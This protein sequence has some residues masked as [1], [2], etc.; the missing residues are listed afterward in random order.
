MAYKKLN[1]HICI[2]SVCSSQLVSYKIKYTADFFLCLV[3]FLRRHV[4]SPHLPSLFLSSVGL[5]VSHM[6]NNEV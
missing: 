6:K 4:G 2:F 1:F 5:L 3:F